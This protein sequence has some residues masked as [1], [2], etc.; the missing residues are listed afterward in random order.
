MDIL[1]AGNVILRATARTGGNK[2]PATYFGEPSNIGDT[3]TDLRKS[4]QI[5]N[6]THKLTAVGDVIDSN[7]E[8]RLIDT[9]N[10][11]M[12]LQLERLME[13]KMEMATLGGKQPVTIG[14]Q[15]AMISCWNSVHGKPDSDKIPDK[16]S[17]SAEEIGKENIASVQKKAVG[18]TSSNEIREALKQKHVESM[19]RA[20][21]RNSGTV[22]KVT[23]PVKNENRMGM[24]SMSMILS[25]T[26]TGNQNISRSMSMVAGNSGVVDAVSKIANANGNIAEVGKEVIQKHVDENL[27][28]KPDTLS[29]VK[30]NETSVTTRQSSYPGAHQGPTTVDKRSSVPLSVDQQKHVRFTVGPT[31]ENTQEVLFCVL[32]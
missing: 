6:M 30:K 28:F 23:Q 11:R 22:T 31:V 32:V 18:R 2:R 4:L 12:S 10:R 27:N 14:N 7:T 25:N 9:A 15:T 5:E 1:E 8:K 13:K 21:R 26:F 16:E 24:R 20:M 17:V 29:A 3:G 19:Q